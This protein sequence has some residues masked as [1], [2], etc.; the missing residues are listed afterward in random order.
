MIVATIKKLIK[1]EILKTKF[2]EINPIIRRI[3]KSIIHFRILMLEIPLIK[4][5]L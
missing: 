1:L 2:K 3:H 5:V 4:F